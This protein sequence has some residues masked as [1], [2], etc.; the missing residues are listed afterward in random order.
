MWGRGRTESLDEILLEEDRVL[1]VGTVTRV[2]KAWNFEHDIHGAIMQ[3]YLKKSGRV[4]FVHQ[5]RGSW[6]SGPGEPFLVWIIPGLGT[7]NRA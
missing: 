5:L 4:K 7:S 2:S 3:L 6:L 1:F